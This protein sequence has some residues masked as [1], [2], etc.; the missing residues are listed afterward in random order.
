MRYSPALAA[1]VSLRESEHT[2][3]HT[4]TSPR[5]ERQITKLQ[6][7]FPMLKQEEGWKAG[8]AKR[9]RRLPRGMGALAGRSMAT[10]E[11]VFT[12]AKIAGIDPVRP[13]EKR[14]I[15]G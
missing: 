14:A 5:T 8:P 11:L 13:N 6:A 9:R 1:L 7:E 3:K 15:P 4:A 10:V 12:G 2:A